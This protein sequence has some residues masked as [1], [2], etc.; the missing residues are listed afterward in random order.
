MGSA[1]KSSD[2]SAAPTVSG[3]VLTL[4]DDAVLAA[5]AMR[6]VLLAGPFTL[7]ETFG[8]RVAVALEADS[9]ADAEHWTRWL[10]ELPGVRKV[11]IAF[12]HLEAAHDR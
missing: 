9:P 2:A 10:G 7:G 12:V 4:A 3:L 8:Q 11:D 1:T 5:A 6:E